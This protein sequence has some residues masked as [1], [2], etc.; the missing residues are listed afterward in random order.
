[1]ILQRVG[2]YRPGNQ[3][4]LFNRSPLWPTYGASFPPPFW[5]SPW[6]GRGRSGASQGVNMLQM[7]Y[8]RWGRLPYSRTIFMNR[9]WDCMK[10]TQKAVRLEALTGHP[11]TGHV[12]YIATQG[13]E[14]Q[15]IRR[16]VRGG[17]MEGGYLSGHQDYL[18][19]TIHL[20]SYLSYIQ[21][22]APLYVTLYNI[23]HPR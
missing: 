2:A 21:I 14:I 9:S 3:S 6:L 18:L 8:L 17:G 16:F 22:T 13:N 12:T 23:T 5:T 20:K 4:Q 10:C 1:M 19:L 15:Y 11:Y 7:G